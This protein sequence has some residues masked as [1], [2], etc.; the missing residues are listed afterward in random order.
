MHESAMVCKHLKQLI[1]EE[2]FDDALLLM[3]PQLG[4]SGT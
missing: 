1:S 4:M 3:G 2:Q